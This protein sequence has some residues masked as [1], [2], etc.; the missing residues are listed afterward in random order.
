MRMPEYPPGTSTPANDDEPRWH[1][2]AQLP[3]IEPAQMAD[4]LVH[5]LGDMAI[6]AIEAQTKYWNAAWSAAR[7]LLDR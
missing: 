6:D 5:E 2:P 1:D 3:D 7:Q 4:D